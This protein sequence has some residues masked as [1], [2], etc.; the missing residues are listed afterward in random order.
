[1]LNNN[2]YI[3]KMKAN[4]VVLMLVVITLTLNSCNN[5]TAQKVVLPE[6][7]TVLDTFDI[8]QYGYDCYLVTHVLEDL[9][10]KVVLILPK[11]ED[12]YFY[13]NLS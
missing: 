13:H 10:E 8:L 6:T 5:S 4:I 11:E 12:H 1:M 3:S 7:I 2:Q 9:P